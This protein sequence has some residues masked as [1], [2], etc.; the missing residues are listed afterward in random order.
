MW[1]DY[2]FQRIRDFK[3]LGSLVNDSSENDVEIKSRPADG[4]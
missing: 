3:Y 2:N 4:N 1:S